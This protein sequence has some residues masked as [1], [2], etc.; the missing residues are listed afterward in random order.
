M[1]KQVNDLVWT[2]LAGSE[3]SY[4]KVCLEGIKQITE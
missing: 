3:F 2:V 1:N 4:S